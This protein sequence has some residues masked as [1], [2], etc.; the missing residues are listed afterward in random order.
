M[1]N[2][3][4]ILPDF[5]SKSLHFPVFFITPQST[6]SLTFPGQQVC[7]L[8]WPQYSNI[9]NKKQQLTNRLRNSSTSSGEKFPPSEK[10]LKQK[11]RERKNY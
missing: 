1:L 9:Q 2:P 11:M 6:N 5:F 3:K 8:Y 4:I 7:L 10:I